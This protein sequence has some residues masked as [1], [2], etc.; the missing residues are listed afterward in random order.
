MSSLRL[1]DQLDQGLS[2]EFDLPLSDYEILV[3][4]NESEK[5]HLR[6]SDLADSVIISRSRLTYRVDRLVGRG[7]VRR[8]VSPEDRRVVF[9]HITPEG[10]AML[11]RAA[12]R[13]V[14]DVR[15]LLFDHLSKAQV[16]QV[17]EIFGPIRTHLES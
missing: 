15:E 8:E 10:Q 14:N 17:R 5:G 1:I 3:S 4:L 6:M 11:D 12:A 2:Q 13:H 9:A 16:E 7:L